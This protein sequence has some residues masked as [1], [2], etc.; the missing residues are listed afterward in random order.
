MSDQFDVD[1][2]FW[3]DLLVSMEE[4]RVLPIVGPEIVTVPT[5]DGEETLEHHLAGRLAERLRV[6][7]DDLGPSYTLN[8]VVC[9]FLGDRG[10]KEDV[11]RRV[12]SLLK[13]AEL[14]PPPRLLDLARMRC[15]DCS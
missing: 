5:P 7:A 15:F 10:R 9:K 11:Y 8:D 4:G 2:Y 14:Q 13:D 3:E 12:R 1:E 6:R